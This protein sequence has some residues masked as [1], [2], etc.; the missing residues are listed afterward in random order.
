MTQ[1][2]KGD[3]VQVTGHEEIFEF[4]GVSGVSDVVI[5]YV[6]L[7]D[8]LYRFPTSWLTHTDCETNNKMTQFKK[9]DKVQ[10]TG[11]D[12]V[13]VFDQYVTNDNRSWVLIGAQPYLLPKAWLFPYAP[14][15]AL[16]KRGDTVEIARETESLGGHELQAGMRSIV[17]DVD[18]TNPF[19]TVVTTKNATGYGTC[20][21]PIADLRIVPKETTPTDYEHNNNKMQ[22]LAY[23]REC[24]DV[25]MK[26]SIHSSRVNDKGSVTT[27]DFKESLKLAQALLRERDE[28]IIIDNQ[29]FE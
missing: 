17:K 21:W 28:F 18:D 25:A 6:I 2:K 16:P 4:D 23:R 20:S 26:I 9:G 1:F 27:I 14:K 11:R 19:L 5:T 15:P 13:F 8:V 3:K 22:S 29:F 12:E 10:V 7:D 24:A